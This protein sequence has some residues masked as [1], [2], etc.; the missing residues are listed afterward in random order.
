M[1]RRP[2]VPRGRPRYVLHVI[3][4]SSNT[5]LYVVKLLL[6]QAMGTL[7]YL[8]RIPFDRL[9]V[10]EPRLDPRA[11]KHDA[12]NPDARNVRSGSSNP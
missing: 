4:R 12:C 1:S 2:C 9:D 6:L 7:T 5:I 8:V 10:R 11:T 3:S